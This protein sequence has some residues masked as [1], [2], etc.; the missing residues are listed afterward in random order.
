MATRPERQGD[1]LV[2]AFMTALIAAFMLMGAESVALLLLD[3]IV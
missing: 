3:R 2:G 1:A